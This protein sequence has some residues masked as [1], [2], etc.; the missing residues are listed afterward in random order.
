M[1]DRVEAL[2]K[3]VE[4]LGRAEFERFSAWFAEYEARNWDDEI[5]CDFEAG[6]LN[7]LIDEARAEREAGTLKDL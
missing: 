5:K 3:E 1:V 4:K 7:F 2:E 6:K